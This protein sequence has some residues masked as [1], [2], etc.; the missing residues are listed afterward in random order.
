M[1]ILSLVT[2]L[3][4]PPRAVAEVASVASPPLVTARST[5]PAVAV[6]ISVIVATMAVA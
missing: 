1:P 6:A 5:T 2:P 3:C 4:V